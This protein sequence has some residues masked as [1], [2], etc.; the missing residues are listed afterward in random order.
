MVDN[1]FLKAMV[2]SRIWCIYELYKSLKDKKIDCKFDVYTEYVWEVN[3][4]F[5]MGTILKIVQM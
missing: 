5:Q 4:K 1:P 3:K 2:Y